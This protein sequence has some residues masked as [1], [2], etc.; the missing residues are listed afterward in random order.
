MTHSGLTVR[1]ASQG[2][3]VAKSI[4]RAGWFRAEV[5]EVL[6]MVGLL[7]LSFAVYQ[8]YWT[9]IRAGH[10]QDAAAQELDSQWANGYVNPRGLRTPE[11]GTAF[12]RMYIPS[13]GSDFN[14]A[15]VEGVADADL[16]I[17]PGHYVDTQMPGELGNVGIAGH[18]VGMGSPFN[19]LGKL[20]TCD[21]IVVET[22][23]TW[24]VY[25]VMPMETGT[26]AD[27][28][29]AEKKASMT[30]GQYSG[31]V[32][33]HITV[34]SDVSV[35]DKVPG[36]GE[37]DPNALQEIITLTTCHPQFSNAERMIIHAMKVETI[38]KST[39]NKPEALTKEVA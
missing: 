2:F 39:G 29:D 1:E 30:T 35:I 37:G 31:V 14:F 34:P 28:F 12:A 7:L 32:G 16:E 20:N 23:T 24:H 22:Q 9:D 38:D 15:I 5:A 4:P 25:R 17:G 3:S 11:L 8:A 18:R 21:A 13:F 36:R 6:F 27:C 19:D 33:R 26:G 10:K